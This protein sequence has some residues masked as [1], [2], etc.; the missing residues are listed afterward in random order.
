MKVKWPYFA[1]L[2]LF[3]HIAPEL[4]CTDMDYLANQP[5]MFHRYH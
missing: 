5:E 4:M 2:A 1:F 3:K